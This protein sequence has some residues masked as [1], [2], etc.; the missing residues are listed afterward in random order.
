MIT[1][2]TPT[3]TFTIRGINLT[4][5]RVSVT[6]K[7]LPM[8]HKTTPI[9]LTVTNPTVT[10]AN[11]ASIV[12]VKLTQAQTA[13][14]VEGKAKVMVNWIGSDGTRNATNPK[15]IDVTANFLQEVLTYG[16]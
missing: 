15:E 7:Q 12:T 13:S 1:Y 8:V 14:F 10:Y 5:M 2:T 6:F 9:M 3:E 4:S 16:G 11:G